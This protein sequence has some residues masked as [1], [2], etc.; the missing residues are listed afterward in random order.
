MPAGF[1]TAS[2]GEARTKPNGLINVVY[3]GAVVLP[4]PQQ[5]GIG[6]LTS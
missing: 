3:V 1:F 6:L 2:M 4:G 5:P